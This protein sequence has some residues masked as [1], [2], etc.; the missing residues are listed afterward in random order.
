MV[1]ERLLDG[2]VV[3]RIRASDVNLRRNLVAGGIF[4]HKLELIQMIALEAA[5]QKERQGLSRA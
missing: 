4:H 2:N 3:H 5:R 1:H